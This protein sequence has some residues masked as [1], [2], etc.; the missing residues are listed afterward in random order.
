MV[1]ALEQRQPRIAV[2]ACANMA[3]HVLYVAFSQQTRASGLLSAQVVDF[4][5]AGRLV[6][7]SWAE[8][9]PGAPGRAPETP[10]RQDLWT[11]PGWRRHK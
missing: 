4:I 1:P 8:V 7:C 11:I 10:E 9:E 5:V 6:G 3:Q 2:Q